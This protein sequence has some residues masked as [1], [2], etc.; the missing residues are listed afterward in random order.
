MIKYDIIVMTIDHYEEVYQL[1]KA[2]KGIGLSKADSKE[3]IIKFLKRNEDLSFIAII[4]N[5]IIG[6]ILGS[7]DGRRG[8][9]HHLAVDLNYRYNGIG[10]SLANACLE[11]FKEIGLEKSHIFVFKDNEPAIKFWDRLGYKLRDDISI[12]SWNIK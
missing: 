3:N 7:H 6:A 9:M 2:I 4:D 12:M 1:W 10:K 5:K 8:Y 11:K